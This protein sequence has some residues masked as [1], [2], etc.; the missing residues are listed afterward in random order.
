[1]GSRIFLY[2]PHSAILACKKLRLDVGIMGYAN[3]QRESLAV[4]AKVLS[5][6]CQHWYHTK[7]K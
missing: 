6:S 7:A 5:S 3:T 2:I 4:T 1:M